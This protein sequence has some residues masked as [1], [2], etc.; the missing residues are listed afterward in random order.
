MTDEKNEATGGVEGF[1][2]LEDLGGDISDL[3]EEAPV[4]TPAETPV[5][6]PAEEPIVDPPV[7][8]PKKEEVYDNPFLTDLNQ[9]EEAKF[10]NFEDLTK[11]FS[12]RIGLEINEPSDF[13]KVFDN[14]SSL[15]ETASKA[16]EYSNTVKQYE[17]LIDSLDD[18]LYELIDM[19]SKGQDYKT[20][21]KDM[22][23][24]SFDFSSSFDQQDPKAM[25][26]RYFPGEFSA[27]DYEEDD[28]PK[29]QFALKQAKNRY[30]NDAKA[31]QDKPTY[32]AKQQVISEEYQAKYNDSL[33]QS[34]GS[35]K[36]LSQ[37]HTKEI[38]D[39]MGTGMNGLLGVF[40]NNDGTW[41]PEAAQNLAYTLY[42]KEA[43]DIMKKQ[44]KNRAISKANEEI[45]QRGNTEGKRINSG[46][47]TPSDDI[48]DNFTR[49]LQDA[50]SSDNP[51]M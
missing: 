22:F 49:H 30:Q 4:E 43:I 21:A 37:S 16:D 39:I 28:N 36:G 31:Q 7:A 51:F 24:N 38:Q 5:E 40:M 19:H 13:N 2:F 29:V 12:E 18:K 14:Y 33:D 44:V 17:G 48:V 42:A 27:E 8:E 45:I 10:E 3:K 6:T 34:L 50:T 41:K 26:D 47:S 35:I 32:K 23:G 46:Q 20:R 25:L 15:K 11:A 9:T 1:T